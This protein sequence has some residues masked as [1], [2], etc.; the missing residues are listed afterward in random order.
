MTFRLVAAII[1]RDIRLNMAGPWE[2]CATL[3]FFILIA[4]LFPFA[5]GDDPLLLSRIGAGIGFT[6][7]ILASLV[8]LDHVFARDYEDGSLDLIAARAGTTLLVPVKALTHWLTRILPLLILLPLYG[9][10]W[11][12]P[13]LG[14]LLLAV[15]L[16]SPALSLLGVAGAALA[17]GSRLGALL[18]MLLVMPLYVPIVIFAMAAQ[19]GGEQAGGAFWMLVGFDLL[20]LGTLPWAGRASIGQAI[21]FS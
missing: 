10:L 14:A 8:S 6:V 18:V 19:A 15:L 20:A 5:I 21:R 13:R 4:I 11:H 9:L 12:Q 3:C 2:I 1:L 7:L 16:A 17:L